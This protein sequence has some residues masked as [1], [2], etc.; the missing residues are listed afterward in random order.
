MQTLQDLKKVVRLSTAGYDL[1]KREFYF[2]QYLMDLFPEDLQDE[3]KVSFLEVVNKAEEDGVYFYE[4]LETGTLVP[5]SL[6]SP[7]NAY[8]ELISQA[9][10]YLVNG[11]DEWEETVEDP[12]REA[13]DSYRTAVYAKNLNRLL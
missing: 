13:M 5:M 7:L 8:P 2:C 6:P 9:L 10:D 11:D 12:L 4:V 3:V 1:L